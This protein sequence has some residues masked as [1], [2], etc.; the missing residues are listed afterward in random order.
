M[1][2]EESVVDADVI[3]GLV[4]DTIAMARQDGTVLPDVI[5]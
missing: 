3:D 1:W 2:T 4:V 5:R